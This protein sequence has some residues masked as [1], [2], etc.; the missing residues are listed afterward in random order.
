VQSLLLVA[1]LSWAVR[2]LAGKRLERRRAGIAAALA[3]ADRFEREV[4]DV[5]AEAR[6]VV[7]R[8]AEEGPRIIQAAQEAAERER[9]AALAAVEAEAARVVRQ[10]REA[11]LREKASVRQEASER[12]V[13]LT[14]ETARRYLD[15]ILTDAERRAM[16]E[17]VIAETLEEMER[18]SRPGPPG[19]P[20]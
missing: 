4:E 18:G 9:E 2:R 12:L 20:T 17:K 11:V 3:E 13:R 6:A 14:T 1:L 7:V 19:D 15:E 8:A 10:A 5:A 16:T